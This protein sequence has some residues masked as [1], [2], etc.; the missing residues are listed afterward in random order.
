MNTA[1]RMESTGI[2]GRIHVSSETALELR[3]HGHGH[4]LSEREDKVEAKGLGVLTTYFV[5]VSQPK[6]IGTRSTFT[7]SIESDSIA[8][9]EAEDLGSSVRRPG[10]SSDID[11]VEQLHSGRDD[12]AVVT[13][14]EV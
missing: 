9:G 10:T 6:T 14:V 13:Q 7:S 5:N 1:S 3:K 11:F 4:W 8:L 2:P 12:L